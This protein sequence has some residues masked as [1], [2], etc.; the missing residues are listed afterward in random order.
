M[1]NRVKNRVMNMQ[2]SPLKWHDVGL[3][4]Y[5]GTI[6]WKLR[7]TFSDGLGMPRYWCYVPLQYRPRDGALI[8]PMRATPAPSAT[9]W[10]LLHQVAYD[11]LMAKRTHKQF[12]MMYYLNKFVPEVEER[13]E[14]IY[15]AFGS[16]LLVRLR[17]ASEERLVIVH[18]G[19]GK[20]SDATFQK[21]RKAPIGKLPKACSDL[22]YTN[23]RWL[24]RVDQTDYVP[25]NNLMI[26]RLT[27]LLATKELKT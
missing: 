23:W 8:V 4:R 24:V 10:I 17:R 7:L 6:Y 21:L 20:I 5:N 16:N 12:P 2:S 26:Y 13:E 14:V 9:E 18:M 19:G 3:A 22:V 15:P 27:E 25:F 1:K 11:Y